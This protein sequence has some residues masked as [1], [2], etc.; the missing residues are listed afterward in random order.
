[1]SLVLFL[2]SVVIH[3]VVMVFVSKGFQL[4]VGFLTL[5]VLL[6]GLEF[7]TFVVFPKLYREIRRTSPANVLKSLIIDAVVV[8]I[9][10]LIRMFVSNAIA[11]I[12]IA[13]ALLIVA[14]VINWIFYTN[15]IKNHKKD[16]RS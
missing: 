5:Y 13:L 12:A 10:C 9:F 4:N 16:K 6:L 2:L 8:A 14:F 15:V 1:M 3:T 7:L 11:L